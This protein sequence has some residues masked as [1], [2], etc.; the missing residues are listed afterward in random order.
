ML[1]S[2]SSAS[3]RLKHIASKDHEKKK[4][5]KQKMNIEI[6][7]ISVLLGTLAFVFFYFLSLATCRVEP[8]GVCVDVVVSYGVACV[9]RYIDTLHG[10]R[11]SPST[12]SNHLTDKKSEKNIQHRTH[13]IP[14]LSLALSLIDPPCLSRH[15]SLLYHI[16][17]SSLRLYKY[18]DIY[19]W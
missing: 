7:I 16:F 13:G 8:D 5:K 11:E 19:L 9:G 15:R 18:I 12:F 3:F 14:S 2:L 10:T 4:K 17:F 1:S 6:I